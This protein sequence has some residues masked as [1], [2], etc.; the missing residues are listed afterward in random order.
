VKKKI[1]KAVALPF[2]LALLWL[3]AGCAQT[4]DPSQGRLPP[5]HEPANPKLPTLF[6]VGV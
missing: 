4:P 6:L 1:T 3:P 2:L 5:L